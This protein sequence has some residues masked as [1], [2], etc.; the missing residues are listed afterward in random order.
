MYTQ[1]FL[2]IAAYHT[3]S[4]FAASSGKT[5]IMA[6]PA[7]WQL[8][9]MHVLQWRLVVVADRQLVAGLHKE[10]VGPDPSGPDSPLKKGTYSDSSINIDMDIDAYL[11]IN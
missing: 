5:H 4:F 3:P 1:V 8:R 9:A 2:N 7:Q 6:G 10:G 11:P